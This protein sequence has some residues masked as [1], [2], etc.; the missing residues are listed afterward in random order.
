MLPSIK[1]QTK[2]YPFVLFSIKK[3]ISINIFS[4]VH[5]NIYQKK[6]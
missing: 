1:E 6:E 2:E 3:L 4:K 5:M